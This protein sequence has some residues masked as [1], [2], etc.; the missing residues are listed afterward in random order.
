MGRRLRI[1]FSLLFYAA[2][3]TVTGRLRHTG[4]V[5]LGR[6]RGASG[7]NVRVF[8]AS[9]AN[10]SPREASLDRRI[11]PWIVKAGPLAALANPAGP[12]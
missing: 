9:S 6:G 10:F 8:Y 3:L 4:T 2:D 1:R 5:T 11:L 12:N 7:R